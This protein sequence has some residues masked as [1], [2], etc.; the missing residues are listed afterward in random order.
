MFSAFS[1][2][3]RPGEHRRNDGEVLRDVVGDGERGQ[4]AAGHQKLLADFDH[5]DELGGVGVEIDHVAGFLGG[6]RAGVH[7]DADVGLGERGSIVGAVAGHGD[8]FAF[9]L[10]ALDQVHLVFRRGLREEVVDTGFAS[11]GSRRKRIVAGDHHGADAHGAKLIEALAHAALHHVFQFNHAKCAA[12]SFR[13]DQRRA[14]GTGN[15][16][17]RIRDLAGEVNIV[18]QPDTLRWL[19]R[20]LCESGSRSCQRQT[21][22]S[23]R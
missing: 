19:R 3:K 1:T 4:R 8:E 2:G 5:L 23:G 17:D 20:H 6:L 18:L 13:D 15:F 12:G 14:A 7:G 11:D 22:G 9:S 21:C 16:S 10:L